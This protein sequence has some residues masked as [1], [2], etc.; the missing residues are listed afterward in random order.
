MSTKHTQET[1]TIFECEQ[2][3]FKQL[4]FY[5]VENSISPM[6][7]VPT[8]LRLHGECSNML[9]DT[10]SDDID[11][12]RFSRFRHETPSIHREQHQY[13]SV[14]K[15]FLKQSTISKV[16]NGAPLVGLG[17]TTSRLHA[18]RSNRW[19]TGMWQFSIC[20]SDDIDTFCFLK[21]NTWNTNHTGA[22]KSHFRLWTFVLEKIEIL[23]SE[24]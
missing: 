3:F 16:E 11:I 2:L 8:P 24:K 6:G 5:E 1:A 21:I 7:L 22:A 14:K 23:R 15:L 9:W 17:H 12:F 20:Q 19:A 10:E 13:S 18:E 4:K